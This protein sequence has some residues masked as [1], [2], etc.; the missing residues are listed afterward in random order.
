MEVVFEVH[1]VHKLPGFDVHKEPLD[2]HQSLGQ[3]SLLSSVKVSLFKHVEQSSTNCPDLSDFHVFFS[4]LLSG[5]QVPLLKLRPPVSQ[6]VLVD[7]TI[8]A[9]ALYTVDIG[10]S[11]A[12]LV[13]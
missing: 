3:S 2:D 10:V 1:R 8:G 9:L 4:S 12:R 6:K 5:S 7:H 11:K 13:P